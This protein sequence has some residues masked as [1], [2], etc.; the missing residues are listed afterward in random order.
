[1]NVASYLNNYFTFTSVVPSTM[2][3]TLKFLIPA[4]LLQNF[5]S[6]GYLVC[7]KSEKNALLV[8]L[9]PPWIHEMR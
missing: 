3:R 9:R 5:S 6:K 7:V 4:I 8:T 1:M 2:Y